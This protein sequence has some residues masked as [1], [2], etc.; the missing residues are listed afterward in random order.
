MYSSRSLRNKTILAQLELLVPLPVYSPTL[1]F[2][3]DRCSE[4]GVDCYYVFLHILAMDICITQVMFTV[5]LHVLA[6][7][8][9]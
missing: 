2:R 1:L 6:F 9:T 4:F 5:V 7:M 8:Q 3:S